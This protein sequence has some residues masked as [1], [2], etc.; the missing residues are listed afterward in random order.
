MFKTWHDQSAID[1]RH[2]LK[3]KI[4]S[5]FVH[6]ENTAS[7]FTNKYKNAEN[8]PDYKGSGNFNGE[9]M[10]IAGWKKSLPD[11]SVFLSLKIEEPYKK[12]H[13]QEDK[14]ITDDEVPF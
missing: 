14:I 10:D 1:K 11:G 7:L 13:P 4:M 8:Q 9:V 5:D 3:G 2:L 6:K 12:E